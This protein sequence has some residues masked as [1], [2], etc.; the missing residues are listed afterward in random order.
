MGITHSDVTNNVKAQADSRLRQESDTYKL[1]NVKGEGELIQ[2]MKKSYAENE[3]LL[4]KEIHKK[5][6]KFLYNNGEGKKV[7]RYFFKQCFT[8]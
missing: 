7:K 8:L 2:L 6:I 5:I 4:N 3:E 1:V